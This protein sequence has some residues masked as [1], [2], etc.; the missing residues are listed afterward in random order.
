MTIEI[1]DIEKL[2]KIKM[3]DEF[4]GCLMEH[5]LPEKAGWDAP[6]KKEESRKNN[7]GVCI[8][9]GEKAIGDKSDDNSIYF[10]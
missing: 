6:G 3:A 5:V 4:R 2:R 1:V 10:V 7:R 8:E 9:L